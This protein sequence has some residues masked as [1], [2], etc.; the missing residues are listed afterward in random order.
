LGEK[1]CQQPNCTGYQGYGVDK[2]KRGE[3]VMN[4][5]KIKATVS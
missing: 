1:S 4:P 5:D 2:I 3:L